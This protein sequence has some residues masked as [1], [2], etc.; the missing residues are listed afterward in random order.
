MPFIGFE[1]SKNFLHSRFIIPRKK[2]ESKKKEEFKLNGQ[3][4]HAHKVGFIHPVTNE[5][6]EFSREVPEY[7]EEV[8]ET[9]RRRQL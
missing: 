8:L 2:R 9:L 3:L 7:F 5:Y 4:L 1:I 6:M